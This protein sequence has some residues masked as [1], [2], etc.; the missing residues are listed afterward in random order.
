MTI[1]V[2]GKRHYEIN[3]FFDFLPR[4]RNTF[5]KQL[6]E[7][8]AEIKKTTLRDILTKTH[9]KLCTLQMAAGFFTATRHSKTLF[10]LKNSEFRCEMKS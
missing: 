7:Y 10:E 9:A 1:T 5:S 3:S 2:P 4:N 8:H 6:F